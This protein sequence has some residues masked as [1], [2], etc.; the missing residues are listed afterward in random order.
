MEW[1]GE[2]RRMEDRGPGK[3]QGARRLVEHKNERVV[4]RVRIQTRDAQGRKSWVQEQHPH[5]PY[6]CD[7]GTS[8]PPPSLLPQ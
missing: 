3:L 5:V 7:L 2:R 6:E 1:R 4:A 8:K